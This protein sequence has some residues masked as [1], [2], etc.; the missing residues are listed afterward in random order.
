MLLLQRGTPWWSTV[1]SF[2]KVGLTDFSFS[3]KLFSRTVISWWMA[4]SRS[5]A[6]RQLPL[7]ASA[8]NAATTV[9]NGL[10]FPG[11]VLC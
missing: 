8:H 6:S 1:R 5:C 3:P 11:V 2:T 7:S 4:T 9:D 10:H